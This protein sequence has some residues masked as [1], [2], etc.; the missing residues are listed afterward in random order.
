ML[1]EIDKSSEALDQ[2]VTGAVRELREENME[3]LERSVLVFVTYTF[4]SLFL[5]TFSTSEC[6]DISHQT[7]LLVD[8]GHHALHHRD[9]PGCGFPGYRRLSL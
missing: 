7:S 5:V 4:G 3:S 9:C 2:A 1:A 6:L 8:P